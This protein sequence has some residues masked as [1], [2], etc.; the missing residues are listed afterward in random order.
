MVDFICYTVALVVLGFMAA[1]QRALLA[2]ALFA[3]IIPFW[4]NATHAL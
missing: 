3:F 1:W 4:L 2:V